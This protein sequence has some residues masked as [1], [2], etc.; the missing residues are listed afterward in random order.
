M[1]TKALITN[2][3]LCVFRDSFTEYLYP[4]FSENFARSSYPWRR[5]L[6]TKYI[7]HEQPD[8]VI[9]EL[10]ERFIFKM[11]DLPLDFKVYQNIM[12]NDKV[13]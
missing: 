1:K 8:I 13:K 5:D 6:N 2:L 3:K 11:I 9:H 10:L 12:L 4:H 7:I